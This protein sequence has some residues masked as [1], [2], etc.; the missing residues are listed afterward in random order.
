MGMKKIKCVPREAEEALGS[1]VL[2]YGM[3]IVKGIE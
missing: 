1:V 2:T 3:G